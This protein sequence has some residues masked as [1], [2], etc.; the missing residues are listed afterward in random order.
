MALEGAA[1]AEQRGNWIEVKRLGHFVP[2]PE[3]ELQEYDDF[4]PEPEP[5]P[6]ALATAIGSPID[7]S[8]AYIPPSAAKTIAIDKLRM[9]LFKLSQKHWRHMGWDDLVPALKC[10]FTEGHLVEVVRALGEGKIMPLEELWEQLR[11]ANDTPIEPKRIEIGMMVQHIGDLHHPVLGIGRVVRKPDKKERVWVD[12]TENKGAPVLL[13]C[14]N[15]AR[16]ASDPKHI[17]VLKMTN[18]V[19]SMVYFV[20]KVMNYVLNE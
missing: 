18:F 8:A 1:D 10:G 6:E 14:A 11:E 2:A 13:P 3:E 16:R 15:M 9:D 19:L 7:P 20:F 4:D 12:F 17:Q 5:E